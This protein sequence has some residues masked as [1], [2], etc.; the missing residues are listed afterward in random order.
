MLRSRQAGVREALSKTFR[1]R[2]T[3]WREPMGM[4]FLPASQTREAVA[5]EIGEASH[6]P[7]AGG[8]RSRSSGSVLGSESPCQHR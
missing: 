4:R 5:L 3:Y 7:A 8:R 2:N 1:I 6:H